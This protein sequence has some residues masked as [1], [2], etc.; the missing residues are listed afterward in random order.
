MINT[1]TSLSE[2]SAISLK[3]II[4]RDELQNL[5]DNK[6]VFEKVTSIEVSRDV[7]YQ[8]H[9]NTANL[10]ESKCTFFE[11]DEEKLKEELTEIVNELNEDDFVYNYADDSECMIEND[12]TSNFSYEIGID[13]FF[14]YRYANLKLVEAWKNLNETCAI[15][16]VIVTILTENLNHKDD[17][18]FL[19]KR[20][21]VKASYLEH[22]EYVKDSSINYEQYFNRGRKIYN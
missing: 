10:S 21:L 20:I 4:G 3:K 6:I 12:D 7:D 9:S 15:E 13:E 14:E 11:D 22:L 5:I 16:Y 2:N 17:R 8:Y 19:E 18:E 1:E